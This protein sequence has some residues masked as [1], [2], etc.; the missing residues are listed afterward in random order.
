MLPLFVVHKIPD[1]A[2]PEEMKICKEKTGRKPVK[3]TE[4]LLGVMKAKKILLYTPLIKWCLRNG[5]RLTA[6]HQSI[7]YEPGMFQRSIMICIS[8]IIKMF[9]M[10]L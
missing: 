5:L 10:L 1:C 8:S 4:M 3:G 6:V 2:I 7:K 9:W